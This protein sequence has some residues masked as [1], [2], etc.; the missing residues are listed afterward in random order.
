M[1]K[2]FLAAILIGSGLFMSRAHASDQDS[3]NA[4]GK[5]VSSAYQIDSIS[6]PENKKELSILVTFRNR[7]L[8][9]I[10][11]SNYGTCFMEMEKKDSDTKYF[12]LLNLSK[13][14]V[15]YDDDFQEGEY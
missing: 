2:T 9:I 6:N 10:P 8:S 1:N 7:K 5:Q 13:D 14:R 12:K 15:E 11:E 3:G 4:S